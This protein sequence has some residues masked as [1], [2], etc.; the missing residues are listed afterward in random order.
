MNDKN[1]QPII[2]NYKDTLFRKLFNGKGNLL[3]LY[4]IMTGNH[5]MDPELLEIV[6]LENAIY[7]NMKNDLAYIID[8]SIYL[9]EHQSTS[10]GNIA[11][12]H[13]FYVAREYKL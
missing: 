5:H 13:L 12:R 3:K 9:C 2:R 4:N 10:S 7:M 11:L 6:T 8:F 1:K